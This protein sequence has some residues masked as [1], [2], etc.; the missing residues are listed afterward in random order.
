MTLSV[1]VG[2]VFVDKLELKIREGGVALCRK[3]SPLPLV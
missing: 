1:V 2:A 3:N